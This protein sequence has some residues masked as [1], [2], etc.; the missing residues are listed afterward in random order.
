MK[1]AHYKHMCNTVYVCILHLQMCKLICSVHCVNRQLQMCKSK[2]SLW[3]HWYW[4]VTVTTVGL[5]G[6]SPASE[7]HPLL[8]PN[9]RGEWPQ[10]K[11][12]KF[13]MVRKSTTGATAKSFFKL[14]AL[15]R[16]AKEKSKMCKCQK[17]FK[18]PPSTQSCVKSLQMY[19]TNQKVQIHQ[20]VHFWPPIRVCHKKSPQ[21]QLKRCGMKLFNKCF[22][23]FPSW[24][25]PQSAY[26]V[27]LGVTARH[28]NCILMYY[29]LIT[30]CCIVFLKSL[31][32]ILMYHGSVFMAFSHLLPCFSHQ[33]RFLWLFWSR[34]ETDQ[35][36]LVCVDRLAL[37]IWIMKSL[38][39]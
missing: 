26:L 14:K 11:K 33:D 22:V 20:Y 9:Q 16:F 28:K 35:D 7:N 32:V 30:K 12:V 29:H 3:Q 31:Y 34:D 24:C 25:F 27:Y 17:M 10:R 23:S 8:P 36:Y 6:A 1:C 4:P 15:L 5:L 13:R 39:P 18:I 2:S 38:K 37:K 19:K 21:M